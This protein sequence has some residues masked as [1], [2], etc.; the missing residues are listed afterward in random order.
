MLPSDLCIAACLGWHMQPNHATHTLVADAATCPRTNAG[1]VDLSQLT[2]D[3]N[4][5][6]YNCNYTPDGMKI[7]LFKILLCEQL[8]SLTNYNAVCNAIVS[9]TNGKL[10][11]P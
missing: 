11:F 5:M 9:F 7:K 10:M 2:V 6:D 8:P 3:S 1:E 4:G